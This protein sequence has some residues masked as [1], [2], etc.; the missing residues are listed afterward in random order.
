M[1][2]EIEGVTKTFGGLRAVNDL[3][4]YVEQGDIL[5]LIGPNG[6]G[7][8]VLVNI[9]TG[10]ERPDKGNGVVQWGKYSGFET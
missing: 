8:T 9:I 6:A 2:L 5:G 3:S 4:I 10:F 1:I 7:K